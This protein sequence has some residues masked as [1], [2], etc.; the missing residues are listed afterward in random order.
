MW[1]I[2]RELTVIN[3]FHPYFIRLKVHR[4]LVSATIRH[5]HCVEDV[6]EVHTTFRSQSVRHVATQKRESE[7]LTGV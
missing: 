6:A 5:I 7:S 1:L 2:V 3:L 4:R